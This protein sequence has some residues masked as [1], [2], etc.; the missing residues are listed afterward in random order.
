MLMVRCLW[1]CLCML[2]SKKLFLGM[3]VYVC[4]P[5]PDEEP[6]AVK[7]VIF[8]VKL[9]VKLFVAINCMLLP[10]YELM[11][12]LYSSVSVHTLPRNKCTI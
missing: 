9:I 4:I 6:V 8:N 1:M 5:K 11:L 12:I 7:V 3:Q 2:S 10:S